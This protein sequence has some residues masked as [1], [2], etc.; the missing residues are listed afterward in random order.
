[1]VWSLCGNQSLGIN[2]GAGGEWGM[3]TTV[4]SEH[5]MSHVRYCLPEGHTHLTC[6]QTYRMEICLGF[7]GLDVV[8]FLH[9]KKKK[10]QSLGSKRSLEVA[11]WIRWPFREGHLLLDLLRWCWAFRFVNPNGYNF[12]LVHWL[13]QQQKKSPF[14]I[15]QVKAWQPH[16]IAGYVGVS[17]RGQT[18]LGCEEG[19]EALIRKLLPR[20]GDRQQGA[21][22]RRTSV[23]PVWEGGLACRPDKASGWFCPCGHL[24]G[25]GQVAFNLWC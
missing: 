17:H 7:T 2:W 6:M 15:S 23:S 25:F 22:D 19:K 8:Q 14:N 10:I 12:N 20:G 16:L 9:W 21:G 1:M 24:C 13:N 11:F 4:S 5:L 18:W 3:G